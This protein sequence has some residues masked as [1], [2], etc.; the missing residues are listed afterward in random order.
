MQCTVPWEI[1]AI[2]THLQAAGFAI[3]VVGGAVRDLLLHKEIA[4]WDF[5][6]NAEPA[7]IQALFPENFYENAFGTVGISRG[8][9]WQL[10]NRNVQELSSEQQD[11]IYEITTFRSESSY[12]DH[13]R[14][15]A[16]AWG[17]T[18]EEDLIRRDFTMNAMALQIP[19]VEFPLAPTV[20]TLAVEAKLIDPHHGQRDLQEQWL[21]AVG[22][23]DVRFTEDALRM[24]RAVRLAAQLQLHIDTA[25]LV[26]L[27]THAGLLEHIAWERIRDEFLKILV[28]NQVEDALTLLAATGLLAYIIPELLATRGIEQR[29]HHEHD[30]WIHSLR[31]CA[32]C[33]SHDPVVRLAALIHDIAKPQTQAPLAES[34]GEFSF[35]N[36]EVAGARTARDIARR[37][38]LSK[39][40][41][42]RV[43]TLVRWHMFHYQTTMT[44][45]AIRR[46]IRR[47]GTEN[48]P[49][50]IALRTG[51]RLG[52]GS[53]S[54]NWRL[55]E[56][57]ERIE[58][59]L[60]QPLKIADL[61]I[62]GHEVMQTLKIPPS[63]RVGEILKL[64]FEKVLEDPARNTPEY[65]RGALQDI[66]TQQKSAPD[67]ESGEL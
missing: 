53:K 50:M 58:G 37:L 61:A 13:R 18:L 12:S 4:D 23:P 57:K 15:D 43:F 6:T 21:R 10:Y 34:P 47:V 28:T 22:D 11:E 45:A 39:D 65:L 32:T 67:T 17:K 63:R 66:Q 46:F 35:Y 36:H 27:Q 19:M 49:D 44:D 48:I 7:A 41:V 42:Q 3:Y 33:P 38:R 8:H 1:A 56:M 51:D 25:V 26:A 20:Q 64:L 16:V 59:Q 5:T 9:L 29:G 62:D 2:V 52:S 55:E 31:S 54:T 30:V 14:P 24:L 60:H 40:D